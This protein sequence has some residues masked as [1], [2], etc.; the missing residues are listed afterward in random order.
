MLCEPRMGGITGDV[1]RGKFWV[2]NASISHCRAGGHARKLYFLPTSPNPDVVVFFFTPSHGPPVVKKREVW[3]GIQWSCETGIDWQYEACVHT[4]VIEVETFISF[5]PPGKP[6][7][8][9]SANSSR[10]AP[11]CFTLLLK[12]GDNGA[13]AMRELFSPYTCSSKILTQVTHDEQLSY[14]LAHTLSQIT[15][16]YYCPCHAIDM[17]MAY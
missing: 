15:P 16:W 1:V 7:V 17:L 13:I 14:V 5:T 8:K 9:L 4:I 3:H 6:L 12:K 10:R 11:G 2:V